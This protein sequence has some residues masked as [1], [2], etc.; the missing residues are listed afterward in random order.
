MARS[1][2][3]RAASRGLA[4]LD[5]IYRY[6]PVANS[7]TPLANVTIGFYDAGIAYAANTN[8]IYVF[9]GLDPNFSVLA[10]TQ[11]YDIASNTWTMGAPMPDAAGRYFQPQSIMRATA[12]ST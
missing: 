7:W 8:K 9:G 10:T 6:D 2:I 1:V 11:I 4:T 12:R 5:A 3:Q